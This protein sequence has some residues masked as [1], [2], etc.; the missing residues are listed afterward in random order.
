MACAVFTDPR[1]EYRCKIP[2]HVAVRP[3]T[4]GAL[5][6]DY[7]SRRLSFVKDRQL[8]SV[9]RHLDGQQTVAQVMDQCDTPDQ[10]KPLF[11]NVIVELLN[12]GMLVHDH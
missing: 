5:L 9:L 6:Y 3:E 11:L 10:N 7:N 12:Q 8:A 4:F 1:S 2:E